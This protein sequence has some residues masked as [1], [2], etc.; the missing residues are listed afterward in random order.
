VVGGALLVVL[1]AVLLGRAAWD[2]T[3]T[4]V[5]AE[6]RRAQV[7]AEAR[8]AWRHPAAADPVVAADVVPGGATA[9]VRIPRFGDD[10]VVP[11]LEGTGADQLAAG[12]GH[13]AGSARPGGVG[14]YALAG[15]R[16]TWGEP[17]RDLPLLRPGDR[18]VVETRDRRLTY[19]I[20]T[21]P[22]SLVVDRTATWVVADRPVDP[23]PAGA[24]TPPGRRL[25]T[26]VTCAEL[27]HTDERLVVFGH[28]V[29]RTAR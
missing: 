24:V 26:L 13:V 22:G 12:L 20:D 6:H 7:V 16:V 2:R 17:L 21:L 10:Y 1:G 3:V 18:V 28:L 11:V 14:N 15:H 29:D 27:V 9:L 5:L 23:D 8:E 25:L 19:A 4:D